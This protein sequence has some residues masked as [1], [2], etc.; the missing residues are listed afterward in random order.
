MADDDDDGVMETMTIT[1]TMM[2]KIK[3]VKI[4]EELH[5]KGT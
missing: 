4:F 5:S 1:T 3:S 2:I